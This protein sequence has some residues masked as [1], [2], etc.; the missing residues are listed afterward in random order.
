MTQDAVVLKNLP[1]GR[2]LVAVTRGTACG[3]NCGS[4]ESCIYQS[5]AQLTAANPVGAPDGAKV[6]IRSASAL[7]YRAAFLVYI[8]PIVFLIAGYALADLA[9]GAQEGI[10][11]LAGFAAML[12]GAAVIV[13]TQKNKKPVPY[14]IIS[15]DRI[16]EG[17]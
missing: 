8:L 3:S 14:E 2:A 16:P 10:C 12:L 9:F 13:R 1:D 17:K 5:E 7:V 15:T 6:T 4:C 11:V